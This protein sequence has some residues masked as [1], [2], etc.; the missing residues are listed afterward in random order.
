MPDQD[1]N[2]RLAGL[3]QEPLFLVALELTGDSK[4][5]VLRVVVDTDSG[6][7]VQQLSDL[8]RS[9]GRVLDEEDLVAGRYRLEC[10]SPGLDRPLQH[11]RLLARAVGRR[12]RV[13]LARIPREVESPPELVGRLLA[14]DGDGIGID[15]DGEVVKVGRERIQAIHHSL[16][17]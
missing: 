14:C 5:R 13:R 16:E 11:P 12:V 17:W 8:S 15:V 9:L 3:V 1:L 4:G 2:S 7:T 10:C 6:V